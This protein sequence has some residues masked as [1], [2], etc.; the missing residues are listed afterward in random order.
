[1]GEPQLRRRRQTA[2]RPDGD[3]SSLDRGQHRPRRAPVLFCST[4]SGS[5]SE[6]ST[7]RPAGDTI[8]S[9]LPLPL[10]SV[11]LSPW[12]ASSP[13]G[14]PSVTTTTRSRTAHPGPCLCLDLNNSDVPAHSAR[15]AALTTATG[16]G[17]EISSST[18]RSAGAPW[19]C[20]PRSHLFFQGL[21]SAEAL[22]ASAAARE[23]FARRSP[24]FPEGAC[25]G[26][27]SARKG[28]VRDLAGRGY[29]AHRR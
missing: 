17:P 1:M 15:A 9:A 19:P 3:A 10:L 8:A 28:G 20:E 27:T 25:C 29:R 6:P 7:S 26:K 2:D 22:T 4:A 16:S 14:K 21:V 12:T 18:S 5:R 11:T 23:Q 13:C 24:N